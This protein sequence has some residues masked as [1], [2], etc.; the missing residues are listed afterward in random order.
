MYIY[1][2][3]LTSGW[4]PWL[5]YYLYKYAINLTKWIVRTGI[6]AK[7]IYWDRFHSITILLTMS[8]IKCILSSSNFRGICQCLNTVSKI[9]VCS[10]LCRTC[11]LL[12]SWTIVVNHF[13]YMFLVVLQVAIV[14]CECIFLS[15]EHL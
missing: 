2:K 4:L 9:E 13:Y 15:L 8:F 3:H 5:E 1:G 12:F 10:L 6:N 11:R 7:S 14:N